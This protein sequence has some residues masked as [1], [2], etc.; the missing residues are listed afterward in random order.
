MHRFKNVILF[1]LLIV[2][3]VTASSTNVTLAKESDLKALPKYLQD[4]AGSK[5]DDIVE[6]DIESPSAGIARYKFVVFVRKDGSKTESRLVAFEILK[7]KDALPNLIWSGKWRLLKD[8]RIGEIKQWRY[9]NKPVVMVTRSTM[10]DT[11]EVEL[12]GFAGPEMKRLNSLQGTKVLL[13]G[14]G[15]DNPKLTIESRE[16]SAKTFTW[17]DEALVQN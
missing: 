11:I 1:Y 12:F 3:L 17:K 9:R 13:E 10:K 15:A 7:N 4:E 5:V 6:T 16:S 2:A 14:S 8:P